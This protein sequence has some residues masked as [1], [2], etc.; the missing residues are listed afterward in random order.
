MDR[1]NINLLSPEDVD[2]DIRR[3]PIR[4][5]AI[6]TWANHIGHYRECWEDPK[7]RALVP[8]DFADQLAAA[9][10][11]PNAKLESQP[12]LDVW[13]SPARRS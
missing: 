3:I 9:T 6:I 4:A 10:A 8:T 2:V 7:I 13:R 12:E 11:I 1:R 5:G